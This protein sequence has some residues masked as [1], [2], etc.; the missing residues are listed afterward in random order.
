MS[1]L[2]FPFSFYR[3]VLFLNSVLCFLLL[4]SRDLA[5]KPCVTSPLRK[6]CEHEFR[7]DIVSNHIPLNTKSVPKSVTER[8][9]TRATTERNRRFSSTGVSGHLQRQPTITTNRSK[10]GTSW[11][12]SQYGK[13]IIFPLPGTYLPVHRDDFPNEL[14]S[15]LFHVEPFLH[16]ADLCQRTRPTAVR[17]DGQ[18]GAPAVR[19]H[20]NLAVVFVRG[21]TADETLNPTL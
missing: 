5:V 4:L 12:E 10:C 18:D 9:K 21:Q 17:T 7:L 15:G 8:R 16:L 3:C 20:F 1:I 13:P 6:R 11:K 19:A 14:L 2:H